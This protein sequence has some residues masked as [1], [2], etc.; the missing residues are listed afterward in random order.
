M[1]ARPTKD[2]INEAK[3]RAAS[4]IGSGPFACPAPYA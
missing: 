2:Q 3:N 1:T 4:R